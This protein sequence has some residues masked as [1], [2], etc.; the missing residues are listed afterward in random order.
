MFPAEL[1]DRC[2]AARQAKIDAAKADAAVDGLTGQLGEAKS[3]AI[4]A[5]ANAATTR[6]QAIK[7]VTDWLD[8]PIEAKQDAPQEGQA[9]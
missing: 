8:A 3:N 6:E 9:A 7:A 4:T 1:A 5:D 2:A